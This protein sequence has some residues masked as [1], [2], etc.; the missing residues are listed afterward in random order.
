MRIKHS[1]C[2]Q[3]NCESVV[4]STVLVIQP[5]RRTLYFRLTKNVQKMWPELG[6]VASTCKPSAHVTEFTILKHIWYLSPSQIGLKVR[7]CLK[8][9]QEGLVLLSVAGSRWQ[10]SHQSFCR[11]FLGFHVVWVRSLE[12][13]SRMSCV[14]IWMLL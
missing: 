10:F 1:C 9:S 12:G 3:I 5:L 6:V 7:P 11:F 14:P 8:V 2:R 13:S 4:G